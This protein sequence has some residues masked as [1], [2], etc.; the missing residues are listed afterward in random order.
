M[1]VYETKQMGTMK[2]AARYEQPP[3][4]FGN[5]VLLQFYNGGAH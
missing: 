1:E 4:R 3:D 5:D 2:E